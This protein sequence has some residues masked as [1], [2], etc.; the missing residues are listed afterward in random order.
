MIYP[1]FRNLDRVK[2]SMTKRDGVRSGARQWPSAEMLPRPS[3][4][5]AQAFAHPG[6]RCWPEQRDVQDDQDGDTQKREQNDTIHV[7]S[8]GTPPLLFGYLT[9]SAGEVP[10]RFR[11]A[12]SDDLSGCRGARWITRSDGS[13]PARIRAFR[14]TVGRQHERIKVRLPHASVDA[15]DRAGDR[16]PAANQFA[17]GDGGVRVEIDLGGIRADR[18]SRRDLP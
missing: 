14:I 5:F 16:Q 15:V 17:D 9:R 7:Q 6:N 1:C 4:G 10:E 8:H 13:G 18:R 11:F 2:F 12:Q 3:D